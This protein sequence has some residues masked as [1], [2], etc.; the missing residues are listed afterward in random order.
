MYGMLIGL[1]GPIAAGK[2]EVAKIL[3]RHGAQVIDADELAHEL[4]SSQSPV[5]HELVKTFGAKI[6][7]RG[8]TINRRKL[9]EIVFSDKKKLKELNRIVHPSLK[10][11]VIRTIEEHRALSTEHGT[12]IIVINAAVL[13]EIGLADYVEE[14]WA[15]MASRETR[16]KRLIRSGLSRTEA[17]CRMRAQASQ[18]GY[19]KMADVVIR[20]EG[21]LKQ[22]N[23][24]VQACLQ[25]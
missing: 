25:F 5:W 22:L 20:N 4:Y 17:E 2:D 1:T 9:G 13:N 15:V 3:R 6:L 14:I 10:E 12:Q 7:K 19:S 24:K 18:K 16:L 8:G 23:A 21:T 11:A